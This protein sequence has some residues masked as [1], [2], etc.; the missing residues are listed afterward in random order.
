VATSLRAAGKLSTGPRRVGGVVG[1]A[2]V[3]TAKEISVLDA[4]TLQNVSLKRKGNFQGHPHPGKPYRVWV[5]DPGRPNMISSLLKGPRSV[6]GRRA[7]PPA[8]LDFFPKPPGRHAPSFMC[9]PRLDRT[10]PIFARPRSWHAS[11]SAGRERQRR[12][13]R[14]GLRLRSSI[15]SPMSVR[16]IEQSHHYVDIVGVTGSIPVAPTINTMT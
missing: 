13:A 7:K 4:R 14:D 16:S 11:G 3:E 10:S 8:A 6:M 12:R 1:P 5:I 9:A 15:E 2:D